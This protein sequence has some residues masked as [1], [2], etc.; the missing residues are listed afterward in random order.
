MGRIVKVEIGG[1]ELEDVDLDLDDSAYG[2]FFSDS[3]CGRMLPRQAGEIMPGSMLAPPLSGR[4]L[5]CDIT[6]R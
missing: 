4:C 3:N 5:R 6:T 1:V 2:A